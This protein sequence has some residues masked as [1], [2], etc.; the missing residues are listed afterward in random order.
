MHRW[1]PVWWLSQKVA[2]LLQVN[3]YLH[4]YSWDFR[5]LLIS[6]SAFQETSLSFH[7]LMSHLCSVDHLV[8]PL[9]RC[10]TLQ[11]ILICL[12]TGPN[13]HSH[14]TQALNKHLTE[15][16]TTSA[17]FFQRISHVGTHM[18]HFH[19]LNTT[20][21]NM[22][23][24]TVHLYDEPSMENWFKT[25]CR[26]QIE[27]VFKI[28]PVTVCNGLVS[29]FHIREWNPSLVSDLADHNKTRVQLFLTAQLDSQC[30]HSP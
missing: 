22:W 30:S 6:N 19:F 14:D 3:I 17:C 20:A 2:E 9:Q 28:F 18:D 4:H 27:W 23:W 12:A 11:R 29:T 10:L 13:R 16:S 26:L 1:E 15:H 5:S 7:A 24:Y 21:P 25:F 8:S